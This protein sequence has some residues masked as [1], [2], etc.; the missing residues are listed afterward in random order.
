ME[1]T[2]SVQTFAL[3]FF[4][5]ILTSLTPCIFPMIPITLSVL[6]AQSLKQSRLKSFLLSIFYVLGI[7]TTYAC[8]GVAAA[9]SGALFGS[10]LANPWVVGMIAVLFIIMGLSFYGLY[11]IQMPAFIR[12][13]YGNKT[14]EQ[15]YL[16]AFLTG[17]VAGIIASPCVGPVLV[18]LLTYV[19]KTQDLALGFIYMFTYALGMGLI[20]IVLGT[21]SGLINK[22]P[23]SG[24]WLKFTKFIFGT[25]LLL[26]S[27]YYLRPILSDSNLLI[28]AGFILV[29]ISGLNGLFEPFNKKFKYSYAKKTV[30]LLFLLAGLGFGFKGFL[31]PP[32]SGTD[33]A[34]ATSQW[35]PY[36][37]EIL[38]AAKAK[39]QIVMIDFFAEWCEAC[40]QLERQT[41]SDPQV[42][43]ILDDFQLVK[44]D[45]TKETH[46]ISEILA[47]YNVTGLPYIIFLNGDGALLPDLTLTGYEPPSKFLTRLSNLKK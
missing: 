20:F 45:A 31:S 44:V 13:K 7:A 6:G 15:N 12:T 34:L 38:A 32:T 27:I 42:K 29:L 36:S 8:L 18:A 5:G 26:M 14:F 41:F 47:K 16:G 35:A 33:P 37:D 4:A 22:L 39:N 23:K 40:H 1:F 17:L 43:S 24:P 2:T 46:E 10:Y 11:D 21:F 19:A 30:A 25:T 9:K 28:Y 3:I